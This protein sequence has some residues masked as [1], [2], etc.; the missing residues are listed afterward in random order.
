MPYYCIAYREDGTVCREPA[1]ILDQQRG[2]M[3]CEE[4]RL[5]PPIPM[6]PPRGSIQKI[7]DKQERL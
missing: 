1:P 4:H 3:V 6:E 7:Q 5:T 2:G